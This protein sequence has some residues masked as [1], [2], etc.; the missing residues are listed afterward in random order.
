MS[1]NDALLRTLCDP[2]YT[3]RAEVI[4]ADQKQLGEDEY[5]VH[6]CHCNPDHAS[7]MCFGN[8]IWIRLKKGETLRDLKER[9]QSKLEIPDEE[10]SAWEFAYHHE[11]ETPLEHLNDDDDII[12]KFPTERAGGWNSRL[13]VGGYDAFVALIHNASVKRRRC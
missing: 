11:P 10:F 7:E 4:P 13:Y 1:N 2:Y 8:P 6:C 9:I 12:S 5:L 3:L